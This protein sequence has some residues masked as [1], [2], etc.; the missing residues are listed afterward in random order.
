MDDSPNREH[1]DLNDGET[2]LPSPRDSFVLET[3]FIIPT[4]NSLRKQKMDRIRKKLGAEVPLHLVFPKDTEAEK[5]PRIS[6]RVTVSSLTEPPHLNVDK[7]CPPLPPLPAARPR[8]HTGPRISHARDSI[9]DASTIHRARR[10]VQAS[11]GANPALRHR[12][13]LTASI[14]SSDFRRAQHRLSFIIESPDE[15]GAGCAEDFGLHV[16]RVTSDADGDVMSEWFGADIKLWSAR[17]GQEARNSTASVASERKKR[18]S[19]YRKPPP[20]VPSEYLDEITNS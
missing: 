12:K 17:I 7:A 1:F 20:P 10:Q 5:T 11:T 15:H 18:S 13:S 3:K 9:A 16:S 2:C 19:S 4:A 14:A 8:K 6:P